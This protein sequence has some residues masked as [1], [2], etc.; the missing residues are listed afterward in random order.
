MVVEK[1]TGGEK[2]GRGLRV[3]EVWLCFV[4]AFVVVSILLC[5][6]SA[7][8]YVASLRSLHLLCRVLRSPAEKRRRGQI[9]KKEEGSPRG[10]EPRTGG[11]AG[12]SGECARE[13][14]ACF[15]VTNKKV[16]VPV[17]T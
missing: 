7:A 8:P 15:E 17:L 16:P 10:E 2:E 4:S 3:D 14:R 12:V 11:C 13:E 6:F 9:W 1:A 5:R